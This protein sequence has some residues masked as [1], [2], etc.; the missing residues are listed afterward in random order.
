[1]WTNKKQ[2]TVIAKSFFLKKTAGPDVSIYNESKQ[3][4]HGIFQAVL[5]ESLKRILQ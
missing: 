2:H 3:Q 1:M 5:P 4:V